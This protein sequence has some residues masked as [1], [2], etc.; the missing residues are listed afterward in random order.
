M[1]AQSDTVVSL[2]NFYPGSE[3]YELE[4][5]SVLRLRMNGA[6]YAVSYGT[7]DFDAPNFAYRYVKGET[8]YW[9]SLVPWK[10]FVIPYL[11]DGRRIV[12]HEIDMTAEQKARLV[13]LL[14][15]N[16]RPENKVYRYNYVLDNCATRPLG[17]V[18]RALGD[19]IVLAAPTEGSQ[20]DGETFRSVMRR[21]HANYPWYQFGIDLALGAG[22]DRPI[23][24]REKAF[25]P[26]ILDTQLDGAN[27]GGRKLV[28][29]T[30]VIND[31]P[32]DN[33]V[34]GPTP[35]YATPLF[36][37][38]A[39]FALTLF[40]C[41]RDFRRHRASVWFYSLVAVIFGLAG[42]LVWF[43]VMV[44]EHF[45]THPNYIMVWLNP[46]WIVASVLVWPHKTRRAAAW[47]MAAESLATFLLMIC[48]PLIPQS[49]NSAFWPLMLAAVLSGGT[50]G[51]II[52]KPTLCPFKGKG[53]Q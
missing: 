46:L 53:R 39:F 10:Y 32:V 29:R 16:L 45:A 17:I 35:W 31:V 24:T 19:S 6:D 50:Y 3:I 25:A 8:D 49:A 41:V 1:W 38:W 52:L 7:F 40:L 37:C 21:Y 27:A 26:V 47:I 15:E 20:A 11:D 33:A 43:L 42:M 22:I 9:V 23:N 14:D 48:W 44:S 12:E 13:C 51:A 30:N 36:V 34:G 2:V 4:G 5:H 18:E 28:S